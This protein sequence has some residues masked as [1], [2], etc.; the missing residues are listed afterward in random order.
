MRE[1]RSCDARFWPEEL[2][3]TVGDMHAAA[4]EVEAAGPPVDEV[5]EAALAPAMAERDRLPGPEKV[6]RPP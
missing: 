5:G 4:A 2:A 6:R 1:A 3:A